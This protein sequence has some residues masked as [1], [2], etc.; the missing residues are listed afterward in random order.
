M[1]AAAPVNGRRRTLLQAELLEGGYA[2]TIE[3]PPNTSRA[4]EFS[5]MESEARDAGRG[6]WSACPGFGR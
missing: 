2:T 3:V 5:A 1:A 6:G 4:G